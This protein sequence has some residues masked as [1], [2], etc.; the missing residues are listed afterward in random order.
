MVPLTTL[1]V[2]LRADLLRN[3]HN[4][5]PRLALNQ[6]GGLQALDREEKSIHHHRGNPPFFLVRGLRPLWCI[7]F[8][9]DQW[10]IPLP[11]FSPGNGAYHSFFCS[12]TSGSGDRPREEGCRS[13]GAYSFSS[14]ATQEDVNGEKMVVSRF[15]ADFFTV[16]C[17]FFTVYA[18]FSRFVC[19]GHKR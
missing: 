16:W 1:I 14:L 7:P 9:P 2:G 6:G 18:D 15:G 11:L 12:V 13:G 17:R 4:I 19:K 3:G 8:F 5:G 10:C